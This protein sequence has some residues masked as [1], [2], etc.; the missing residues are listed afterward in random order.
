MRL[1]APKGHGR[2]NHD[3]WDFRITMIVCCFFPL[4]E[5]QRAPR[6][7]EALLISVMV[8]LGELYAERLRFY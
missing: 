6:L 1:G 2:L 8:I 7:S 4:V 3:L 5:M